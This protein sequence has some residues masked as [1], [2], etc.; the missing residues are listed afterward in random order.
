MHR[1]KQYKGGFIAIGGRGD[2][3]LK[4][5]EGSKA[6]QSEAKRSEA[7]RSESKRSEPQ[8][9]EAKRCEA[10]RSEDKQYGGGGMGGL[11]GKEGSK[12]KQSEAKRSE[13]HRSDA[14]INE[15][16]PFSKSAWISLTE[17]QYTC[18]HMPLRSKAKR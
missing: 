5:K 18:L 17:H 10:K 1:L 14:K 15:A 3:G 8:R 11:K 9:N 16:M 7:K 2:G 13:A 6:K 4:G 12:A